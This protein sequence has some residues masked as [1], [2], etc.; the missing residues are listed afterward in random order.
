MAS[1]R[2]EHCSVAYIRWLVSEDLDLP[3]LPKGK[4]ET[5]AEFWARAERAGLL[6]QALTLY[7]RFEAEQEE[8]KHVPRETKAQFTQ[9]V[10]REGRQAEVERERAKLVASGMT[11]REVH[12]A[13]VERFQPLDGT[14]TR[15]WE[16]PNPWQYGRLFLRKADEQ[17]LLAK[18]DED[19]DELA[20]EREEAQN[21][22]YWARYRREEGIALA[23]ARR[24]S[25]QQSEA[26]PT[27]QPVVPEAPLAPGT[28]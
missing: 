7:D 28:A 20:A 14:E 15:P 13:L 6:H 9:R 1:A 16:T 12:A 17:M 22:L 4:T 3:A 25:R 27:G 21:R 2:Y 18:A 19:Y 5:A 26:Q 11:Q 24:R 10:E 8:W 23:A